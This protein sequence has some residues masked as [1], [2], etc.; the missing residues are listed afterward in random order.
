MLITNNAGVSELGNYTFYVSLIEGGYF[1]L[2]SGSIKLNTYYL[3]TPSSSL[4]RFK[5]KYNLFYVLPLVTV[6]AVAFALMHSLIGIIA[7]LILLVYYFAFDESSMFL[8][9]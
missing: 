9:E 5:K 1:L 6:I 3:S 7:S 2:F 4:S 8:V